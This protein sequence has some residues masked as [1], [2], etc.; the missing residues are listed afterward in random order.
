MYDKEIDTFDWKNN[1]QYLRIKLNVM[2]SRALTIKSV[3]HH[4]IKHGG[5]LE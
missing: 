3:C 5:S 2:C 1:V 4:F